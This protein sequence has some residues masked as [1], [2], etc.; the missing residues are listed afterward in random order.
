[1]LGPLLQNREAEDIL[2]VQISNCVSGSEQNSSSMNDSDTNTSTSITEIDAK[3]A[4]EDDIKL[5][6]T[7]D[8]REAEISV[9]AISI[10]HGF[11]K[12]G[13]GDLFV[14]TSKLLYALYGFNDGDESNSDG[15]IRA[16]V[17]MEILCNLLC[18][19]ILA[20]IDSSSSDSSN[21]K[22]MD[23]Q[24]LCRRHSL[25]LAM[26]SLD[27]HPAEEKS[28]DGDKLETENEIPLFLLQLI[29]R[30]GIVALCSI[31]DEFFKLM[32]FAVLKGEDIRTVGGGT[33]AVV[34]SPILV[35]LTRVA[36]SSM[37]G[38]A[39]LKGIIFPNSWE[40]DLNEDDN[41]KM[42]PTDIPEGSLRANLIGLMTSLDSVLKRYCAELLYALCEEGTGEFVGRTGFGNAIAL[43]Q[44]KGL[45]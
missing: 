41:Q 6:T 29:S 14:E 38:R 33:P 9:S 20:P 45:I 4:S 21:I 37:E 5:K 25:Q 2:L 15:I 1:L 23:M 11:V 18:D 13:W 30:G 24:R 36:T 44:I 26:L 34:L 19:V 35:L 39:E 8:S 32:D 12:T 42:D 22:G 28:T 3:T 7:R 16:S 17:D 31:L 40:E 10:G 27:L 43:M